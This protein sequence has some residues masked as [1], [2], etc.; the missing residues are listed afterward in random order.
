MLFKKT[1]DI[2]LRKYF[3]KIEKKKLINKYIYINLLKKSPFKQTKNFIKK[4]VSLKGSKVKITNRC[5]LTNRKHSVYKKFS[6]SRLVLRDLMQF[7]II[8]G[9]AKSVW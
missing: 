1:K 5:L 3:L 2:L 7:G 8:P 9:Y 4:F 6:L